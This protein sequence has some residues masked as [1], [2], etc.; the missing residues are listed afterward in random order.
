M[1]PP[2]IVFNIFISAC[3]T[4][5]FYRQE[6]KNMDMQEGM[7]AMK[8]G[9][10]MTVQNGEMKLL[11]EDVTMEDGTRIMMDGT[12]RMADGT[13]RRMKEGETLYPGRKPPDNT[14]MP[15]MGSTE[16]MT[17]TETHDPT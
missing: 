12:V 8:D 2:T 13:T 3:N 17:G 16:E 1:T 9:E 15:D 5:P 6:K 7:I 11:E 10:V 4:R 14:T